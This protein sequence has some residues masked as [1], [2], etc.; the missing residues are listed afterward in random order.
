MSRFLSIFRSDSWGNI[1]PLTGLQTIEYYNPPLINILCDLFHVLVGSWDLHS[2][3]RHQKLRGSRQLRADDLGESPLTIAVRWQSTLKLHLLKLL[4]LSL[5][6][7]LPARPNKFRQLFIAWTN[8]WVNW[9]S[10]VHRR[11][12]GPVCIPDVCKYRGILLACSVWPISGDSGIAP[13][14][15][16]SDDMTFVWPWPLMVP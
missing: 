2:L 9:Q 3:I 15:I 13:K 11:D 12:T 6:E 10:I 5:T 1:Q 7:N 14:E 4:F 16:E 8:R